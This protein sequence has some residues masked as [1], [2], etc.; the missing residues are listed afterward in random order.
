M[1]VESLNF[2]LENL[3]P[4]VAILINLLLLLPSSQPILQNNF[5]LAEMF[6]SDI[7]LFVSFLS[8]SYLLGLISAILSRFFVDWLSEHFSR[9]W[10]LRWLSH[11]TY[12]QLKSSL[13]SL[14]SEELNWR[15]AWNEA[16]RA[17]LKYV[18]ANGTEKVIA[19]IWK[20]R[21]QGR[22][23]RNLF[24]PL[25][26]S[27][28]VLTQWLQIKNGWVVVTILCFVSVFSICFYSYAEYTTFAEAILHLP[29]VDDKKSGRE[30]KTQRWSIGTIFPFLRQ[31]RN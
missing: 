11:K 10:M 1:K 9:P 6:K 21:E 17:S 24:F 20:R 25:L 30:E 27:S 16:Y 23:V 22:L 2:Y 7:T 29:E 14:P 18:I 13:V 31:P 12:G 4:G 19:E 15:R 8:I 5:L 28:A 3:L 26:L